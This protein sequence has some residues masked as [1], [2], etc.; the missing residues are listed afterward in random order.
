MAFFKFLMKN[1]VIRTNPVIGI[2]VPKIPKHIP[3]APAELSLNTALDERFEFL[4]NHSSEKTEQLILELLYATGIRRS[5]LINLTVEDVDVF[6]MELRVKGKGSK[7]R[8]VPLNQRV[9][10]LLKDYLTERTSSNGLPW[11]FL[12][13]KGQKIYPQY[14]YR[15][16]HNFLTLVHGADRKSP[17]ILRHSFAT[18]L[19]LNGADLN[20]VKELLGHSSLAS[21]QVYTGHDLDELKRVFLNTHPKA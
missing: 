9:T 5:E 6:R 8:I 2:V 3:Q 4:I 7:W 19:L 17:H 20:A 1:H 14:V 10:S 21:T 13:E 12:T 11:L 16:V 15:V 18:H